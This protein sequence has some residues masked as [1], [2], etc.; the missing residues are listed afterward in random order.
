VRQGGAT[1]TRMVERT[2][3]RCR[4]ISGAGVRA[5][6]AATVL[7]TGAHDV[8]ASGSLAGASLHDTF[9][10]LN[11]PAPPPPAARTS[12]KY[13]LCARLSMTNRPGA[14]RP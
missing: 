13:E 2:A 4:I 7:V 9:E 12:R 8:H 11:L 14:Y 10:V 5:E 1:I 6:N 3:G